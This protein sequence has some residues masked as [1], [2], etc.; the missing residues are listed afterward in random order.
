MLFRWY[1]KQYG[2]YLRTNKI[3]GLQELLFDTLDYTPVYSILR[4]EPTTAVFTS[5]TDCKN[6]LDSGFT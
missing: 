5:P 2:D 4:A 3:L 1:L 6:I